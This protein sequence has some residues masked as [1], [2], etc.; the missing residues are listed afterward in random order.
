MNNTLRIPLIEILGE[1][2]IMP[3]GT[4]RE[5][6]SRRHAEAL[7]QAARNGALDEA[8]KFMESR[9]V[10]ASDFYASQIRA[11]ERLK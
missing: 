2:L 5:I 7:M 10:M 3:D 6:F 8:A 11:L 9:K 4:S 1:R